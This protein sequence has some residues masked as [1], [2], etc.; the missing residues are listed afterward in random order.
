M[1]TAN[2]N[3]TRRGPGS[4]ARP[5]QCWGVVLALTTLV[6]VNSVIAVGEVNTLTGGPFQGN[7]GS[8]SGYVNGDTLNVAQFN[9]PMGL[10]LD[11]TGNLLFVAD[12]DNNAIRRLNLSGNVTE[13]FVTTG[14]NKPV[15]LA[16]DAQDYL[17]V[18]N[19]GNGSNG[20]L[21]KFNKHKN[22]LGT[23]A[24][25]LANAT[26][27]ALDG[28]ANVYLTVQ[29][30]TV[31]RINATS[32]NVVGVIPDAGTFL[33]GIAV[34]DSGLLALSDSGRHGIWLLNPDNGTKTPLT[35]FNTSGDEFGLPG[36][37]RFNQPW[38]IAKAGGGML[39][40]ADRGNHRVKLVDS[41]GTVSPFYGTASA[42]WL[43]GWPW[44]G[45]YDGDACDNGFGSCAEARGTAGVTVA[46]DG[47]VFSTETYYH[48][49]RKVSGTGLIGPGGG[50]GGGSGTNIVVTPPAL[51]PDTGYFPMGQILTISSPNPDVFYTTDG[52]DP[53]LTSQRVTMNGNTGTIR[54]DSPDKD[55]T[56]LRVRAY[57]GTNASVVVRG[58]PASANRIGV[59][60]GFTPQIHAGI[61]STIVLPVVADL[62]TNDRIRSFQFRVEVA[63]DTT[64]ANNISDQFR[65]LSI[66]S[67]D[68]VSVVTAAQGATS[69]VYSATAY[70]IPA[71][72]GR[73]QRGLAISAIGT[74]ANVVF[75][76][77]AVVAMLAVPIPATAQEGQTYAINVLEASATADGLQT[78]IALPAMPAATILVTNVPYTVGDSAPGSWY[79]AGSFGNGDL[80]NA[81][82]NNAFYASLGLRVPHPFSDAYDAMDTYPADGPGF[83][84]GDGLIRFLDWQLV[85][86]RALRLDTNNWQ[87]SWSTGGVRVNNAAT[88]MVRF[89][90]DPDFGLPAGGWFREALVGAVPVGNAIP[91]N[92]VD[93]PVYVRTAP[94]CPLSGLQFRASVT[95]NGGAPAV[96]QPA[97]FIPAGS[98]GAP[99]S[100]VTLVG[101][102]GCGWS[103]GSVSFA[104]Q[105]SNFL[106]WVRF[107]VPLSAQIGQT[108]TVQFSSADGAPDS[109]T[110]YTFE[111]RRATVAVQ[112]AAPPARLTSDEWQITFFGAVGTPE[113]NDA[114]D[115]DEDGVLNWQ[116]FLAGTA[117]HDAGSRLAFGPLETLGSGA[118][119]QVVLRWPTVRGKVYEVMQSGSPG[120]AAWTWRQT[121]LGDGGEAVF[122]ETEGGTAPRFYRLRV[123]P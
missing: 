36:F 81:D 40:V 30:N 49:I 123:Q 72:G 21:Q 101:E 26:A 118:S 19:Q 80:N 50:G 82:V 2:F 12:R 84:G 45:W 16:M 44:P 63:P 67:N 59:P 31:L 119:R 97:Q 71:G 98:V 116:E 92:T 100:Q 87:R 24:G 27:V 51:S 22:L 107:T 96:T 52:T 34:L 88:L 115:P 103:L 117:P 70:S 7:A 86:R 10:V 94:G 75:S 93:V 29:G 18:V 8:Y 58:Q 57:L 55:L 79:N 23:L 77:Y 85:L 28:S 3:R 106:G 74:N 9:T 47:T 64:H 65:T 11:S 102:V 83:V 120:G 62:R 4:E 76:N 114:A 99:G 111:T 38:Q 69:A 108:Y 68:F 54:W 41:F 37:A 6:S 39:V 121:I 61:G 78:P 53:N 122:V 33:R 90:G 13:T 17:Y 46:A 109:S 60:S 32:T 95:A 1:K 112:A 48:I 15:A 104:P 66:L 42:D 5:S 105:T 73:L 89:A 56:W 25:N 35:G 43:P 14:I 91:N 20:T 110:Q 113:G